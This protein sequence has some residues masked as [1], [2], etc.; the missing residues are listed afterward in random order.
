MPIENKTRTKS[1]DLK[2]NS[3]NLTEKIQNMKY[4]NKENKLTKK[5]TPKKIINNTQNNKLSNN[6]NFNNKNYGMNP[7]QSINEKY[8]MQFLKNLK[9]F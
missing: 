3:T 2:M 1:L 8:R 4:F 5:K 7:K 9:K 6:F